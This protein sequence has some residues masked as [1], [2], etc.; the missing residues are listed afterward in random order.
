VVKLSENSPNRR[1][2]IS[3]SEIAQYSFCSVAWYLQRCGISPESPKLDEG[4]EKHREVGR[5]VEI[6][7]RGEEV[8]A[9]LNRIVLV[10]VL[11]ALLLFITVWLL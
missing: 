11:A 5:V 9:A 6:V 7:Q 10:L 1:Y 3:A 2:V 4:A 8:S